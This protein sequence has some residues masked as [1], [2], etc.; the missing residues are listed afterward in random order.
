MIRGPIPTRATCP[1]CKEPLFLQNAREPTC[2]ACGEPVRVS[3]AHRRRISLEALGVVALI[4]LATYRQTS[5]GPWI[6]GLA[7]WW[8]LVAFLMMATRPATYETGY[9]QPRM[10]FIAAF[11]GTFVSMFVCQFVAFLALSFL[12]GARSADIQE[13]LG[14]LS[15]PLAWISPQ[16]LITPKRNFFDVC[17]IMLGNS[18]LIALP[19]FIAVK[20]VQSTMRRNKTMQIGINGSVG[21]DEE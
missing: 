15:V 13:L 2:V 19:V 7:L 5:A 4:A 9:E 20:I 21:E 16:F 17:G 14:M 10:T 6:V 3:W 1:K 8:L 11:L 12:V 18:F